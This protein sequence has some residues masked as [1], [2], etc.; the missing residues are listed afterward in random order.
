MWTLAD[1]CDELGANWTDVLCLL[2]FAAGNGPV[3]ALDLTLRVEVG[4]PISLIIYSI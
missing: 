1:V 3:D 2:R 4:I